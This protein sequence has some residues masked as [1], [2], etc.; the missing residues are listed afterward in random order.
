MATRKQLVKDRSDLANKL[1]K[2]NGGKKVPVG[3][4]RETF[5]LLKKMEIAGFA[6]GA[7]SIYKMLREEA[8]AEGKLLVAKKRKAAKKKSKR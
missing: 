6:S 8:V 3:Q 1:T 4:I 7:K 5:K 2:L